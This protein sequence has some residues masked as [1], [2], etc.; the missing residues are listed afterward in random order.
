MKLKT[1]IIRIFIFLIFSVIFSSCA[2]TKI[3]HSTSPV[4]VTNT[5]KVYILPPNQM[6]GVVDEMQVLVG[7]FGNTSFT[8]FSYFQS[9][10]SR[11]LISLFNEFGTDMGS[12]FYDGNKVEFNSP[13]FPK[14]LRCEY[15]ILDIQNAYYKTESLKSLYEN[16]GLMF[17]EETANESRIRRIKNQEKII[18]EITI[19]PE[20]VK[21][22]NYLRGY[23]Y[24]L[25]KVED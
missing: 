9:D 17:E 2:T 3:Q 24:N 1:F 6:T 15:I 11:L 21:I 22:V 23:E 20:S 18:E 4:Y 13:Y 10:S 12:L 8:F 7:K 14:N 5:N 19:K 16:C 25:S